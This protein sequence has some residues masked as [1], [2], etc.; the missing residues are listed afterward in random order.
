[1]IKILL[2]TIFEFIIF[3][4]VASADDTTNAPSALLTMDTLNNVTRLAAGD[5]LSYAVAEDEETAKEV[6]VS[7]TGEMEIPEL[8]RLMAKG[9]TCQQLALDIKK[10]LEKKKYFKATVI[11]GINVLN[12]NRGRV[13]LSGAIRMQGPQEI[14]G[15][16]AF[17]V[18]KA[19]L[20]AGGFTDWA[21]QKSVR[22]TRQKKT[23]ESGIETIWIN[24]Q[25]I[26]KYGN[27]DNDVPLEPGD[28]IYVGER[29]FR[30]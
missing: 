15:D 27:V 5:R 16:E 26:L 28:L 2:L 13:Y 25:G 3:A 24:V 11:L 20:R 12:K 23:P 6:V 18:S 21:N 29:T 14:P 10:E 19:I 4:S 7:D 9:K 22:I 17:T 1:M 30:F 8:G